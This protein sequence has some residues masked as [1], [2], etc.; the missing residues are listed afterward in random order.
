MVD[1]S[2][3]TLSV[4]PMNNGHASSQDQI[5]KIGNSTGPNMVNNNCTPVGNGPLL[6]QL[7]DAVT[8]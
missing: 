3:Q 1:N 6:T 2:T 5:H 8:L 7:K 4:A